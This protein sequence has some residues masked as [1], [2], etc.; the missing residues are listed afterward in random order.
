MP[1]GA[2][3]TDWERGGAI[4][5]TDLDL[6][7]RRQGKVRDV[8]DLPGSRLLVV[9]TDRLSAFDV[10]MPTPIPGKGEMLT[11]M[12]NFW[13]ARTVHIVPNHLTGRPVSRVV[14][15]P[16]DLALVEGRAVIVRRLGALPIEAVVR[17]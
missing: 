3:K 2:S 7:G 15:D 5:R 10:V 11:Q 14:T 17:G 8:Y 9:A 1:A 16:E 4:F 13:F 12:S 6:P